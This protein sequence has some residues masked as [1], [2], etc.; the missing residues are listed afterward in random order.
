M[1]INETKNTY[2]FLKDEVVVGRIL[3]QPMSYGI[4]IT[5][6]W[7]NPDFRGQGLASQFMLEITDILR[8]R[9]QKCTATCSY[10]IQWFEKHSEQGDVL[11]Q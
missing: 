9:N 8:D 1:N 3:Y 7:T 5:Q 6:V 2:E 4:E 11:F 10:A